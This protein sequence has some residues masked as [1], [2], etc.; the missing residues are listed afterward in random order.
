LKKPLS[1]RLVYTGNVARS[2]YL[3]TGISYEYKTF[4]GVQTLYVPGPAE[5]EEFRKLSRPDLKPTEGLTAALEIE[6]NDPSGENW[7]GDLPVVINLVIT[8]HS[9][10][11]IEI[12]ASADNFL[13][14]SAVDERTAT[15]ASLLRSSDPDVKLAMIKP[16]Q[17]LR[18]RW[19]VEVLKESPLSR[20]WL[21]TI[22]TKCA[23]TNPRKNKSGAMWRGERLIS[24]SVERYYFPH[25]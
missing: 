11:I 13:F 21:G 15:R 5:E 7:I 19:D 8:N 16:R 18:L 10:R 6:G 17:T 14:S 25:G 22:N 2:L 24:N 1:N 20:G 9:K 23:Y 3:I 12:D 4:E